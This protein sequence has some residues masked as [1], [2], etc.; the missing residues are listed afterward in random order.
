MDIVTREII[1]LIDWSDD[2]FFRSPSISHDGTRLTYFTKSEQ[3][4]KDSLNE[5]HIQNID[6]SDDHV[7]VSGVW[8]TRN[9][10]WSPDDSQIA[11]LSERDGTWAI[12]IVNVDGSNLR[13]V[14]EPVSSL[15]I[16]FTWSA[17]GES[18]AFS[19]ASLYFMDQKSGN[20][21]AYESLYILDLQSGEA[22]KLFTADYPNT[23]GGLSWQP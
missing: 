18:L 23:I 6:G 2:F 22:I 21:V 13:R 16:S 12:Y 15:P 20:I 11:F 8:T 4:G 17:G 3:P 19:D 5:I 7:L 1:P 14:S 10:I 9:P